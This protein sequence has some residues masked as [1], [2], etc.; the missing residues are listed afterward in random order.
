MQVRV[1]VAGFPKQK[2]RLGMPNA[3]HEM[4]ERKLPHGMIWN[5]PWQPAE[6]CLPVYKRHEQGFFQ[7]TAKLKV[8]DDSQSQELK[9]S[10][11]VLNAASQFESPFSRICL[12]VC[13]GCMCMYVSVWYVCLYVCLCMFL[14]VLNVI[15]ILLCCVC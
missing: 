5:T 1:E 13:M 9:L 14:Y 3:G 4:V 6:R 8:D 2:A 12:Y 7:P 10:N 11:Q 15:C